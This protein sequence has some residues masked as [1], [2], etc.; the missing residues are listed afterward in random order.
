MKTYCW[1]V[2]TTSSCRISGSRGTTWSRKTAR[3]KR[4][5]RS[6]AVML[7]PR[8]KYWGVYLTNRTR[9][10]SGPSAWCC[11]RWYLDRCRSMTRLTRNYSKCVPFFCFIFHIS[12]DE[13]ERTAFTSY[14]NYL[15]KNIKFWISKIPI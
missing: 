15:S 14:F 13:A 6:A 2:I 7:T 12:I 9:P 1:M 4:A 5:T 10:T 8:R 11:T 3:W